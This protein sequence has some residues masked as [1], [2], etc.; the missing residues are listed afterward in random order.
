M[1]HPGEP[2]RLGGEL[3]PMQSRARGGGVTLSEDQ[4]GHVRNDAQPFDTRSPGGEAEWDSAGLDLLL[5]PRNPPSQGGLGD[6]KSPSDLSS[7]EA[8]YRS[9][10]ERNLSRCRQ[11]G[12]AAHEQQDQRVIRICRTVDRI[13]LLLG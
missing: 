7:G 13:S 8:A 2:N 6:Q 10:G 4:V 9:Q 5:R 11:G 3:D 1:N 12:M